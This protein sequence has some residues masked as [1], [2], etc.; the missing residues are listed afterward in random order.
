MNPTLPLSDED[1]TS[2]RVALAKW[3]GWTQVFRN[4]FGEEWKHPTS[5]FVFDQGMLP[6]YPASLNACHEI[7]VKLTDEQ[8]KAFRDQLISISLDAERN[9]NFDR[10]Y[11]SASAEHRSLALYLSLGLDKQ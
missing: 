6:N 1:K 2:I 4:K 3:M 11:V 7:E 8:H 10:L 9:R 5:G